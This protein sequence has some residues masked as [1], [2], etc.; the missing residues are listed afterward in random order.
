MLLHRNKICETDISLRH[1]YSRLLL[2]PT[3]SLILNALQFMDKHITLFFIHNVMINGV[4][5]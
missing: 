4:C 3:A 1:V 2:H 5:F